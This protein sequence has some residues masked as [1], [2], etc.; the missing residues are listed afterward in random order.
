M[1]TTKSRTQTASEKLLLR[2]KEIW[3]SQDFNVHQFELKQIEVDAKKLCLNADWSIVSQAFTILGFICG[4]KE[5]VAGVLSNFNNAIKY[6]PSD[7]SVHNN[8]SVCLDYFG[9]YSQSYKESKI[10]FEADPTD[11]QYVRLCVQSC[12]ACCRFREANILL[13]TWKKFQPENEDLKKYASFID[14]VIKYLDEYHL[15]DDELERLQKIQEDVLLS[16]GMRPE[17]FFFQGYYDEMDDMRCF[18]REIFLNQP[19]EKIVELDN[20]L[21]QKMAKADPPIP[22]LVLRSTIFSFTSDPSPSIKSFGN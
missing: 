12:C 13:D 6:Q 22:F 7:S 1:P 9:R 19:V 4:M 3:E 10:A 8:F 11:L 16:A 15:K 14:E 5:D 20:L 18:Y 2:I 21:D 17:M